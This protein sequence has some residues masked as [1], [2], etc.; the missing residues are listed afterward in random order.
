M[1]YVLQTMTGKEEELVRMIRTIVPQDLYE[2]CFVAYYERIWR[3]QQQSIV[4]VE[5]LFPGYLFILTN[6]PNELFFQLKRV[7]AMSKLM[8][9]GNFTFLSL[10]TG[11][12][13]FLEELLHADHIAH[14][15]YVKTDGKGKVLQVSDL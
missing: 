9:D 15:S 4:H 5:R 6:Q 3:R 13:E 14:L 11:E 1:W 2:D 7:P 12:A 10:E 8:A